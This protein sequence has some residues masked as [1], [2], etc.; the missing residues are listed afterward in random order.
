MYGPGR[1]QCGRGHWFTL[2]T[3]NGLPSGQDAKNPPGFCRIFRQLAAFVGGFMSLSAARELA[4]SWI[5]A[6]GLTTRVA[7]A[8]QGFSDSATTTG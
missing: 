6:N 3:F 7:R 5:S 1:L 2:F 8:S 4:H